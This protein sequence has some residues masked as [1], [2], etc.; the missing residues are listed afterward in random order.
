[1]DV[2]PRGFASDLALVRVHAAR[3]SDEIRADLRR[4]K[5]PLQRRCAALPQ[6]TVRAQPSGQGAGAPRRVIVGSLKV[7]GSSRATAGRWRYWWQTRPLTGLLAG[8]L[9]IALVGWRVWS[10]LNGHPA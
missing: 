2:G 8:W 7:R 1:M 4:W 5:R 9:A 3:R 6:N 10:A